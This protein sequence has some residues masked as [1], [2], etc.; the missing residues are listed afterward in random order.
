MADKSIG[1]LTAA[2]QLNDD[3]LLVVEQQGQAMK[4]TGRQFS[5]FARGAV[6]AYTQTAASAAAGAQASQK[7]AEAAAERSEAARDSILV[8]EERLAQAVEEAEADRAAADESAQ[9]AEHY[10]GLAQ[11]EADRAT[12]PA[13]AGVYN[14]V[15]T[16]RVTGEKYALIVEDGR[17]KLLGVAD[18][19]DAV[20]VNLIDA[21]TG[22]A[23]AVVVDSGRLAIEEV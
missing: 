3:S 15:L 18:T 23:Y 9:L 5:D 12:V 11:A 8:D 13:A 6:I 4:L 22:T 2:P 17:L 19:L 21:A 1:E 16:D 20:N 14:V 10:A 7:T